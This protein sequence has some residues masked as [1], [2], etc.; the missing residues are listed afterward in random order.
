MSRRANVFC[1]FALLAFSVMM[2]FFLF[3]VLRT[4]ERNTNIKRALLGLKE[5][6]EFC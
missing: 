5:F 6:A 1:I 4:P 3:Y 2:A